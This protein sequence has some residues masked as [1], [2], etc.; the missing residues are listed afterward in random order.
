MMAAPSDDLKT[1]K[2]TLMH[3]LFIRPGLIGRVAGIGL[4]A[5]ITAS[6]SLPIKPP[7]AQNA[8]RLNPLV[9]LHTPAIEANG[10]PAEFL[11]LMRPM[12][13]DNGFDT[14]EMMYSSQAQQLKPYRDSRWLAPPADL[15]ADA[16]TQTLIRQPWVQG[17]VPNSAGAPVVLSMSCHLG[18]LEHDLGASTGHVRLA[19]S[20][21]WLDSAA[22]SVRAS[23][24]FDES[25]AIDQN[26][27]A[28]FAA[29]SQ[30]LADRAITEIVQQTRQLLS[31]PALVRSDIDE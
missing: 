7:I 24:H 5:A 1:E 3:H 15:L 22:H 25:V 27:A 26:D 31:H 11:I 19:M 9:T 21:L 18:R 10:K 20:C 14:S 12:M 16:I 13:A 4:L 28:H 2:D 8:Y 6:C 29:A 17:V 30:K 23:W